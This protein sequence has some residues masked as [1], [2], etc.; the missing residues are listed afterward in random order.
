MI[1]SWL[2]YI[3]YYCPSSLRSP[4]FNLVFHILDLGDGAGVEDGQRLPGICLQGFQ[5]DEG[6]SAVA[7]HALNLNLATKIPA[8]Y[9]YLEIFSFET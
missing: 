1:T 4:I 7:I 3:T 6:V 8:R 9:R 5:V 2:T